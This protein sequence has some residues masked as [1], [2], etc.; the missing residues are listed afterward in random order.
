VTVLAADQVAQLADQAGIPR[1]QLT[2]CV[3]IA[4]AESGLDTAATGINRNPDTH[5]V[6]SRDR[7]LWQINDYWHPD[8]SDACAYDAVCNAQAMARIS[9]RGTNWTPWSTF[10]SGA[11]QSHMT[12]AQLA[13]NYYFAHK[14]GQGSLLPPLDNT[15][16]ATV[17]QYIFTHNQAYWNR[18]DV[19]SAQ[20]A[21]HWDDVG[22]EYIDEVST[23]FWL[24]DDI[25][26]NWA[27]GHHE[28]VFGEYVKEGGLN[29][30]AGP[31][32]PTPT[33]TPAPT[34]TSGQIVG[35]IAAGHGPIATTARLLQRITDETMDAKYGPGNRTGPIMG[36]IIQ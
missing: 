18:A 4:W 36:G 11:Y 34:D 29:P 2:V 25:K 15:W 26:T 28:N 9:S 13:V 23:A 21:G 5:E 31:P 1:S 12:A 30:Q 7:G 6:L 24:R 32:T 20:W 19:V 16:R 22:G 14:T 8:V 17:L 27:A 10:N 35:D 33:P 3:A